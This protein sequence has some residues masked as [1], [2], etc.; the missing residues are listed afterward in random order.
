MAMNLSPAALLAM[1][2]ADPDPDMRRAAQKQPVALSSL[3]V[4]R[5][6]TGAVAADKLKLLDEV[7]NLPDV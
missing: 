2:S 4:A 7:A 3:R 6:L 5:V 1:A